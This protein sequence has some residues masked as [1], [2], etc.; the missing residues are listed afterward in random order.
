MISKK[1]LSAVAPQFNFNDDMTMDENEI[2][3]WKDGEMHCDI[4]IYELA[5]KCKEWALV[6]GYDIGS[7]INEA[8]IVQ[9]D[10]VG[11]EFTANSEPEAIFQACE[12][13]LNEM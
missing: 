9:N 10:L 3:F 1:L 11:E 13:I 6:H 4:N 12:R 8:W 2:V 7:T 5:H